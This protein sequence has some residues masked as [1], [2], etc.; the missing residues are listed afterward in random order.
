MMV[1]SIIR[2]IAEHLMQ[3]SK[4]L[5]QDEVDTLVSEITSAKRIFLMGAGRSGLASKAFA[6]RLAQLG[7]VAYVVGETITPGMNKD[8]LFILVSGSGETLSVVSAAKVANDMGV[9]T[10]AVT[11][12]KDSALGKF[13]DHVVVIR[14]KTKVD[15]EKDH[16]KHQIQGRH[17]SLAPMGTLFEDTTMVFFDGVI[18]RLMKELKR[19]EKTMRDLHAT[20][21]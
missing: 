17:S 11:S 16:L 15:I 13:A 8:D 12:Y 14:G 20:I 5:D 1:E 9:E 2:E 18:S 21:E 19:G 3:V 10:I 6:M 4:E 7:L